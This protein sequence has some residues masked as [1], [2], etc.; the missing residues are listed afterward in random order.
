MATPIPGNANEFIEKQLDDRLEEIE[1]HFKA[2]GLSFTG[3]IYWAVETQVKNLIE[4]QKAKKQ[5]KKSLV[6]ILTTMG[7]YI[8][9]VK[10]IVDTI[11]HHYKRV[12]FIIPNYAFSAGTVLAL[13]G[14]EIHMDYF[15]QLGPIDPQVDTGRGRM[16]PALGYLEQYNRLVKKATSGTITPA[17]VQLL[18]TGF[19]QAELYQYEQ[20]RDL[21]ISLIKEWLVKYKFKNW[22]RTKKRGLKVTPLLRRTRAQEIATILNKTERWHAHGCGISMA[23]LKRELNLMIEDFGKN[24]EIDRKIGNYYNLLDDYMTKRGNSGVLHMV[25]KYRP[26]K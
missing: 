21:S 1:K 26:Y 8:E 22:K 25:G 18:I 20:A 19:D 24:A 12:I 7:G 2:D 4:S 6:V 15:S 14:D 11:R 10:R 9:V 5:K 13:S 17:E 16:V 3:P 23:V